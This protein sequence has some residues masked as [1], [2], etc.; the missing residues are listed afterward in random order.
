[1]ILNIG[2]VREL[3]IASDKFGIFD[4]NNLKDLD[5]NKWR[6]YVNASDLFTWFENTEDGQEILSKIDTIPDDFKESFLSLFDYTSCYRD[7]NDSKSIYNIGVIFHKELKRITISFEKKV[8]ISDLKLFLEMANYLDA[9][10]LV[11]G[12][13]IIDEKVIAEL[14]M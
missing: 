7:W 5:Y 10:L 1:M 6:D 3:Y 14:Q 11:D 4:K 13:K 12:T 2:E 9:L 8:T